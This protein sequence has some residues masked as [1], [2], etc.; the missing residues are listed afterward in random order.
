MTNKLTY[1]LKPGI[2]FL[3]MGKSTNI[4]LNPDRSNTINSKKQILY[5]D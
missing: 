2:N 5:P 1:T 4:F 3:N